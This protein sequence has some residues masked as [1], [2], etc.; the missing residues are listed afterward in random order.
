MKF[1]CGKTYATRVKELMPALER[2]RERVSQWQ[3]WFAWRPVRLGDNDCRWLEWVERKPTHCHITD[4]DYW[5]DGFLRFMNTY[6]YVWACFF[7]YRAAKGN[8]LGSEG[9]SQ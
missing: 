3:R 6:P 2:E 4:G 7:E 8:G 5:T 9:R 1:N